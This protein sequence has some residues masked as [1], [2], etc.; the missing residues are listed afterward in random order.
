MTAENSV[1]TAAIRV[2]IRI[3][4]LFGRPDFVSSVLN[5]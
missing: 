3:L 1:K 5:H 4:G 2:M